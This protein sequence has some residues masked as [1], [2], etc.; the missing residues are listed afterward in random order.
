MLWLQRLQRLLLLCTKMFIG[1]ANNSTVGGVIRGSN[2][3]NPATLS[4]AV[5]LDAQDTSSVVITS[6]VVSQWSDRSGNNRNATQATSANRPLL[7]TNQI[8]GFNA[9]VTDGVNDSLNVA[10]W[11]TVAQPFT[12][13]LVF[14]PVV[15]TKGRWVSQSFPPTGTTDQGDVYYSTGAT[16][17][18]RL[19]AGLATGTDVS[20][21]AGTSYIRVAEVNGASSNV[22]TNGTAAGVQNVGTQ[23]LGGLALGWDGITGTTYSNTRYGEVLIFAGLLS[24]TNRQKVEGYLAWKWNLQASLPVA[25]PYKNGPP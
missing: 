5:W 9:I 7:S 8:G 2:R 20:C 3:F 1:I 25:H 19:V 12:R 22:Y 11:A 4:P 13:V 18:I 16:D 10:S 6:G 15:V 14:N 21:V 23:S 24:A 17:T